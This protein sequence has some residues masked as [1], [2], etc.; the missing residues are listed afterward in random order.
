MA[1]PWCVSHAPISFPSLPIA[2]S[3]NSKISGGTLWRGIMALLKNFF[4]PPHL[5]GFILALAS[6]LQK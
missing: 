2:T 5:C 3:G 1:R 6:V 4:P